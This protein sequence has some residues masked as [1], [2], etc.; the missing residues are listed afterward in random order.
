MTVGCGGWVRLCDGLVRWFDVTVGCL[1]AN[2]TPDELVVR[3]HTEL[4]HTLLSH[5]RLA[6]S[7]SVVSHRR[8]FWR[9]IVSL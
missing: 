2:H 9:L 1:Q 8:I 7:R 3:R 6:L 5:P 4:D